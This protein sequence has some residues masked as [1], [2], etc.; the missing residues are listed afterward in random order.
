MWGSEGASVS[1]DYPESAL[2]TD[3]TWVWG[4]EVST[5]CLEVGR[6][7]SELCLEY[8]TN[9]LVC[10]LTQGPPWKLPENTKGGGGSGL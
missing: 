8:D 1:W 5:S 10:G 3:I 4:S 2:A 9:R 6:K 7:D